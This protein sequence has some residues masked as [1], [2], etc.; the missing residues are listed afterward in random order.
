MV[1]CHYT[2]IVSVEVTGS[3][4]AAAPA[5]SVYPNPVSG[6][7]F[8]LTVANLA[9][10]SYTVQLTS[11]AGEVVCSQ[12]LSLTGGAASQKVTMKRSLSCGVYLLTVVGQNGAAAATAKVVAQ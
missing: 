12:P 4:T 5:V 9:G 8:T 1:R 2:G 3:S 7:S 10:G 6:T 11:A